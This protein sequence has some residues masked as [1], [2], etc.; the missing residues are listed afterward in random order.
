MLGRHSAQE[1]LQLMS[2]L[3]GVSVLLICESNE[4]NGCAGRQNGDPACHTRGAPASV[5]AVSAPAQSGAGMAHGFAP[6]GTLTADHRPG[7]RPFVTTT[8][9]RGLC[10][11]KRPSL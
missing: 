11:F 10:R 3:V 9:G 2:A 4:G 5:A 6:F 7:P 1:L 8:G